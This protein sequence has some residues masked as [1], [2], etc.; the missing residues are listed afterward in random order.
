MKVE[1]LDVPTGK[2]T[3]QAEVSKNGKVS[4]TQTFNAASSSQP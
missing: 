4:F 1:T 2:K 3:Y